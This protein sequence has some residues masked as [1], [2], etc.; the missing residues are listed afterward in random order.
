MCRAA[1][2][3]RELF[4]VVFRQTSG[5]KNAGPAPL[6]LKFMTLEV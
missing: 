3:Q 5:A 6:H 2:P 4:D 1:C